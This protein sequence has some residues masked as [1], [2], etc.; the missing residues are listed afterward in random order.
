MSSL[1]GE[2]SAM[3]TRKGGRWSPAHTFS[4]GGVKLNRVTVRN[5]PLDWVVSADHLY[6]VG[7]SDTEQY[8]SCDII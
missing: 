2:L 6:L 1:R 5:L 3:R 4:K 8:S 7:S